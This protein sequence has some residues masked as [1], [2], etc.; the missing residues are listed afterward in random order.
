MQDLTT[1]KTGASDTSKDRAPVIPASEAAQKRALYSWLLKALVL[2]FAI[3]L[4]QA[5]TSLPENVRRTQSYAFE[6]SAD[7]SLSR[8]TE[9]I[10]LTP[11]NDIS[12][13]L[14]LD[15][16]DE[17][18]MWRLMLADLARESL[19]I[20]YFIWKGDISGALLAERIIR[21]ADRGVRVRILIDDVTLMGKDRG[22]NALN[23]HPN[24]EIR[25]FNPWGARHGLKVILGLEFMFHLKRLNHRM[26]N[27]LMVADNC[28]AI[29][30]G[31]N[32]GNE[33]FGLNKKHNFID[34]DVVAAGSIA[35]DI[36][37]S[38]DI[39][40]N[41]KWAYPA[42]S[43]RGSS[44]KDTL[45]EL[46]KVLAKLISAEE[47]NLACFNRERGDWDTRLC[48]FKQK[49]VDGSAEVVYDEPLLGVD[50]APVELMESLQDVAKDA[51]KE[52]LISSPYFIPHG[53]FYE[54]LQKF[55]EEGVRLRVLTNSLASTNHP[56][57]I[58]SYKSHRR[59]FIQG[60]GE[61]YELRVDAQIKHVYD[62]FPV[63]ARLLG[64]HS[65]VII[66]DRHRVFIGSLNL[67]PRSIYINTEMGLIIE[68]PELAEEVA[69]LLERYMMPENSWRVRLEENGA[70]VWESSDDTVRRQPARNLWQRFN[71]G[72][73]GLLPLEEQL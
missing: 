33:Y 46:K 40:W 44:S 8:F 30:G 15:R 64:L 22:M 73:M 52:I 18:L 20:Q 56:L 62:T 72:F 43:L 26:H 14:V 24:I 11:D 59:P 65:K 42:E 61:L 34:L 60:G 16:N 5:C 6:P 19:D 45:P 10:G 71:V 66:I 7:S 31:R 25:T 63:E 27:K 70:L 38:F 50:T 36:S 53:N 9:G 58:S 1:L 69:D 47:E 17:A 37:T 4:T 35:R 55:T 49:K 48:R 57:V 3:A 12:G 41:S 68:S 32:I 21:A 23:Q 28:M 51:R 2:T 54:G 67:D 13:F 29:V 39:Y